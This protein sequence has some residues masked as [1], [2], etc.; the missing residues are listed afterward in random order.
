MAPILASRGGVSAR[1]FGLFGAS[2][3]ALNSYESIATITGTGSSGTISFTSIPSTYKHLQVRWMGK[4]TSTGTYTA[5]TFNGDSGASYARHS[6]YG[7]GSSAGVEAYASNSSMSGGFLTASTD[8]G[9]GVAVLDILD[10]TNTSKNKTL[11]GL[12]GRDN[13]GSGIVA[14]ISG[15]WFSTSA[16]NRLDIVVNAG[17]WSTTSIFALY[18]IKG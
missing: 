16:V 13:N 3:A 7:N 14:L 2:A 1:A 4:S 5:L 15:A 11:R 10:Y 17:S 6:I 18:G 8:T 9:F 12:T